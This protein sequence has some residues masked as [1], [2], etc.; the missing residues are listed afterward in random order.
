MKIARIDDQPEIF[1]SIQ[2]EGKSIGRPSVFVRASLCNLHCVW[3]DTDYTWNWTG[4]DFKHRRDSEA[5][6]RKY[7]KGEQI[8]DLT[9]DEVVRHVAQFDCRNV[10]LTG[11][12][13]MLQQDDFVVVMNQLRMSDSEYWFEAETNG[14]IQPNDAFDALVNQY[15]V[16]P[17]TA[18]SGNSFEMR[19]RPDALSSFVQNP[20][21]TFKFVVESRDDL[22]EIDE[23]AARLCISPERVFLMPEG[24]DSRLLM[25][26]QQWIIEECKQRGFNFS[27]RLHIHLYG[28]RRGV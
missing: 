6:Y 18:N 8:L 16:S 26:Q 20:K 21:S 9:P 10:V 19:V 11:G 28:N 22:S 4:T 13:P 23:L 15:N 2:G 12:E 27:D 3:C 5:G 17:K 1:F 7:R 24:T 14:T 25:K